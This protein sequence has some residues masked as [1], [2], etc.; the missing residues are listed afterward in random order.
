MDTNLRDLYANILH[1]GVQARNT[2]LDVETAYPELSMRLED[3]VTALAYVGSEI[4]ELLLGEDTEDVDEAEFEHGYE[5][6]NLD[7][8]VDLCDDIDDGMYEPYTF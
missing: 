2:S 8:P 6:L 7:G 3:V 1:L 4:D 5:E